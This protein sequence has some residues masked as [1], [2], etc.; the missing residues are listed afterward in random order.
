MAIYNLFHKRTFE[1]YEVTHRDSQE[2]C[3]VCET[4]L[5]PPYKCYYMSDYYAFLCS[6]LCRDMFIFQ[7]I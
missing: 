6:D 5:T 2:M 1:C 3:R 4:R 7:N